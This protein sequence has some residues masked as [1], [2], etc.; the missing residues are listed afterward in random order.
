MRRFT[1][2]ELLIV[3]GIIGILTSILLPSLQ[4]GRA[5][6]RQSLCLSN[7]K[8]VATAVFLYAIDDDR[9]AP[10]SY[11]TG[12]EWIQRLAPEYLDVKIRKKSVFQCPDGVV[13]EDGDLNSSN[14]AMNI[15]LSGKQRD[16]GSTVTD[17]YSLNRGGNTSETCMLMDS[18]REWTGAHPWNMNHPS[19]IQTEG[20]GY[21]IARHLIRANVIFLDGHGKSKSDQF[22]LNQN[23][24]AGTFWDPLK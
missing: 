10:Q 18:Y 14:V 23:D 17:S 4:K 13:L 6:A 5:K 12:N 16:D 11:S 3:I 8:Q 20:N 19:R 2:L 15:F 24:P 21:K 9:Y 1:L 22:L 7:Q